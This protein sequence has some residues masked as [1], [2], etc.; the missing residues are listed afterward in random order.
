VIACPEDLDMGEY[1]S[2]VVARRF[3]PEYF[4]SVSG[5]NRLMV[6][7]DFYRAFEEFEFVLVHQ[8]DAFVFSDQL[9]DW[10]G[11]GHDY[12][13]APWIDVGWIDY[14]NPP[15]TLVGNGGFSLRKIETMLGVCERFARRIAAWKGNED[16]FWSYFA[17][18]NWPGYR[19]PSTEEALSFAFDRSPAKC[20]ELTGGK[21]PFGCHAWPSY[22]EFWAP[23]MVNA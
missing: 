13:G 7:A 14:Q 5:Y 12:V 6:S 21:L 11:R 1:G 23:H 19:L 8:L 2:G 22:R 17:S 10:C 18:T 15:P 3:A 16:G 20:F 4:R 9:L